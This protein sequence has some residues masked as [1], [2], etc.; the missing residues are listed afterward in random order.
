MSHF[1]IVSK[2]IDNSRLVRFTA[3]GSGREMLRHLGLGGLLTLVIFLYAWQHFQCIQLSYQV[4]SLRS[5]QAQATELHRQLTLESASLRAP[6]RIDEIARQ[7]LGLIA[8]TAG[9][10]Q[11]FEAPSEPILAEMQP[12]DSLRGR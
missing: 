10:L 11:P 4:E 2:R 8:P 12:A 3:P 5:Q 7:Q 6:A 1:H 9:Q